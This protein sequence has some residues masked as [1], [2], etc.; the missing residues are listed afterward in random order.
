MGKWVC[1]ML[2]QFGYVMLL[3]ILSILLSI[4]ADV[5]PPFYIYLS[6]L[7]YYSDKNLYLTFNKTICLIEIFC[8]LAQCGNCVKGPEKTIYL[9]T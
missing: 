8:R 1:L 3:Q 2:Y 9:H 6:N 7:F 4:I 5:L